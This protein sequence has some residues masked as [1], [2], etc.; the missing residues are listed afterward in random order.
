MSNIDLF[1]INEVPSF[2]ATAIGNVY[3]EPRR[4]GDVAG[5]EVER[6]S[7]ASYIINK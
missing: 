1:T 3:S 5:D 2:S 7:R 6:S 4:L